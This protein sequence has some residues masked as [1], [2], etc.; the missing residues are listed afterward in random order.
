[1]NW[2][3]IIYLTLLISSIAIGPVFR[4]FKNGKEMFAAAV[5]S[6]MIILVSGFHAAHPLLATVFTIV[7]LKFCPKSHIHIVSF[8][9][10]FSY[11]LFFRLCH[12]FGL[13]GAPPHTNAIQMI[14]TLKLVGICFEVH[15]TWVKKKKLKVTESDEEKQQVKLELKYEEVNPSGIDVFYYAFNY[16]GVLTGPYYRFR[17]YQDMIHFP[18]EKEN[19]DFLAA[20]LHRVRYVPLY[21]FM[22]L[23]SSH[24]FPLS[25]AESREIFTDYSF[26]YRVFF[27]TPIFFTFRM[28]IYTGFVLSECICIMAG[29]GAYPVR[30]KNRP[31]KGPSNYQELEKSTKSEEYDFEAVHNIDEWGSD[32]TPTVREGMKCWNMTV[33]Y[34]LAFNVYKRLKFSKA[35]KEAITMFTSAFWH[36]VYAG[37]YLS[38]LTVPFI[39]A[40]EDFYERI[41]RRKLSPTGQKIYD[42]ITWIIKMQQFAYMG[43]AFLLLRIDTTIHYWRS[44]GFIYHGLIVFMHAIGPAKKKL[45]KARNTSVVGDVKVQFVRH[46]GKGESMKEKKITEGDVIDITNIVDDDPRT[47]KNN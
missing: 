28:R 43:M 25:F 5:G 37:Y 22:F 30:A 47:K 16:I 4:S 1:M 9:G 11:L 40:V 33:Q 24:F 45:E 31:G 44:I 18:S 3:D 26:L 8:I 29:L 20:T 46:S 39:L 12:F 10:L 14:L 36:G 32:F 41:I 6:L 35:V 13:P 21:A 38:M 23:L 27:M 34:W 42:F 2:D 17:T 19:P 7:L 15:D